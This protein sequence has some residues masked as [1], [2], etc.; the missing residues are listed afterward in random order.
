MSGNEL[1][2]KCVADGPEAQLGPKIIRGLNE[3]ALVAV[4][5]KDAGFSISVGGQVVGMVLTVETLQTW[6][7]NSLCHLPEGRRHQR[8]MSAPPAA[9]RHS[10]TI[11][12]RATSE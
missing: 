2:H 1:G 3:F 7:G 6:H 10:G 9:L 11:S 4:G 12:S 5:L 8:P